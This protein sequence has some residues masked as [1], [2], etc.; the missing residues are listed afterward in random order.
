MNNIKNLLVIAI[1]ATTIVLGTSFIPMQSYADRDNDDDD[2]KNKDLKP[3]VIASYE[4]DKESASQGQDQ[5]NFCHNADDCEQANQGQQI[6]GKDNDAKGFNDQSDSLSPSALGTGTGQGTTPTPITSRSVEGNGDA[7]NTSFNSRLN[8]PDN[9]ALAATIKFAASETNGVTTGTFVIET[10]TFGDKSGTINQISMDRN[11]NTFTL[12]GTE[13]A[14][15]A[16]ST[17]GGGT[18]PNP[19]T[20]SGQCATGT[21]IQFNANQSPQNPVTGFPPSAKSATFMG[22]ANCVS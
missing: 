12:T 1:I 20:I 21:P 2:K 8:C 11:T 10:S 5:D 15:Q 16:C 6:T 13:T 9:S 17:F 14:D 7:P 4:S 18:V 3:S 22:N 19:I